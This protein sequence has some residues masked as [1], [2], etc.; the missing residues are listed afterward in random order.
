MIE[1]I[2]VL[3]VDYFWTRICNSSSVEGYWL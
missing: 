1:Y 2:Y 3:T